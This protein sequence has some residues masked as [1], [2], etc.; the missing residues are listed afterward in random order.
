MTMTLER[1]QLANTVEPKDLKKDTNRKKKKGVPIFF[2][3]KRC[4]AADG[5]IWGPILQFFETY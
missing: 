4:L 2:F 3:F 5:E 1:R